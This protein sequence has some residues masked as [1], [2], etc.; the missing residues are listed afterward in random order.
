MNTNKQNYFICLEEYLDNISLT[1]NKISS[2]NVGSWE[3]FKLNCK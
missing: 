1:G 2:K 3:Y